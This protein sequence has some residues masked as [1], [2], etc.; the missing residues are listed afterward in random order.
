[1][2]PVNSLRYVSP[3][4]V[5]PDGEYA[6]VA[7]S[8]T[9]VLGATGGAVGDCIFGVLITPI[10]SGVV[11]APG[12]TL[13]DGSNTAITL[14]AAGTLLQVT[15]VYIPLNLVSTN[16]PWKIITG[17]GATVVAVGKFT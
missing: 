14:L 17:A 1:M 7:V 4:E 13:T 11:G 2:P 12:V 16:G 15:P 10:A 8:T 9:K 6:T 5:V 3:M